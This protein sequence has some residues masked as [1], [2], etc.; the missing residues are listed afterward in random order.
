MVA[1]RRIRGT[2]HRS[3][4]ASGRV[5]RAHCRG[6]RQDTAQACDPRKRDLPPCRCRSDPRAE[7]DQL[8]DGAAVVPFRR[9]RGG[10][11]AAAPAEPAAVQPATTR[12][13]RPGSG[14]QHRGQLH[15]EHKLAVLQRRNDP[16]L[17]LADGGHHGAVVPLLRERHRRGDCARARLRPPLGTNGRQ[18][19]GRSDPGHALRAV[20]DLR[21]RDALSRL[22]GRAANVRA[23]YRGD[24]PRRRPSGPRARPRGI[25]G[26]RSS[27]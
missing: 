9:H 4:E 24:D 27:C 18:F 1:D 2:D 8:H 14:V 10:L 16:Q 17:S 12:C 7:L 19:L 6:T 21:R 23:L 20:A 13:R 26:R 25:S 15:D 5:H 3:R 11:R 22:A